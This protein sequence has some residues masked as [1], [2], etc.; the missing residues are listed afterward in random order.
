MTENEKSEVRAMV[1]GLR[2]EVYRRMGQFERD[3]V[4]GRTKEGVRC[5][6]GKRW[7]LQEG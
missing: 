2:D 3:K 7:G 5:W 1:L 6:V 4:R